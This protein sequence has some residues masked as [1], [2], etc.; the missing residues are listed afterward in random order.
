MLLSNQGNRIHDFSWKNP[1][2]G[3]FTLCKK[4]DRLNNLIAI[5]LEVF[6]KN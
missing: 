2:S 6:H 5:I 3:H 4:I 1:I